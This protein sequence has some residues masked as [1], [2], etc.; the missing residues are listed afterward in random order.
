MTLT[1]SR[2]KELFHYNNET[3]LFTFLYSRPTSRYLK[4]KIAG[5]SDCQYGYINLFVDGKLYRAHRIAWLYMTGKWPSEKIDHKNGVTDDNR[6]CNLREA[7]NGENLQNMRKARKDN[8]TGFLGV[9]PCNGR[10]RAAISV[11]GKKYHL[12]YHDNAEDAYAAYIKEKRDKH[13]FCTL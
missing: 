12:G 1:Q 2:L 5:A 13:P 11:S 10:F 3:G 9:Y 4:G 6:W 7:T 8:S